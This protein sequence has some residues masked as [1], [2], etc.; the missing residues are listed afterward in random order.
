ADGSDSDVFDDD[1]EVVDLES[2]YTIESTLGKGG[3]GEVLLATDTRLNR[4]V[5]IKRILGSAARSKTA[6]NR[7]L[8]EAQ[9]IAALNHSNIV[10]IYDY[11]RAKDGPFLIMEYVE[12]SSLLDRCRK[13]AIP[14]E[15]SIDLICQL[16]DG[17]GRAHAANIIHRDIKPA[18]VLL[19]TEGVPKLTD[20]GLAKDEA[21]DT[22][23]T[24]QG[25]VL[26]TLDFMPPEQRKDAALTDA[27]SDLWSL[28][29]TLYQMLTG[30]SPRVIDLDEVPSNL[31]KCV[32]KALKTRKDDRYQT[33]LDL[34]QA[35]QE[36]SSNTI[37]ELPPKIELGAGE[38]P[39]CHARNDAGRKFCN[40][41][42]ASLRVGCLE[43]EVE[44][45]AWDKFCPECGCDQNVALNDKIEGFMQQL[46]RAEELLAN[47]AFEESRN[48]VDPVAALADTRFEEVVGRAVK[49]QSTID[50]RR[51]QE[52]QTAENKFNEAK[53]HMAAFDYESAIRIL[54]NVPEPIRRKVDAGEGTLDAFLGGLI[55]DK[56]EFD[57]L[58]K[59]IKTRIKNRELT[60]LHEEVGRAVELRPNHRQLLKL[61]RQLRL[62][63]LKRQIADL[64]R[65][66]KGKKFN[67]TSRETLQLCVLTQEYLTQR[68]GDITIQKLE[69]SSWKR[70]IKIRYRGTN[71]SKVKLDELKYLTDRTAELLGNIG[72]KKIFLNGLVDLSDAAAESLS[73]HSGELHLGG[74]TAVSDAGAE[75][76]SKHKGDLILDGLL[77]LSD[78]AAESLS[79]HKGYLYLDGLTFL[80]DRAAESLSKHKSGFSCDGLANLS[81]SVAES[82]SKYSGDL[83]FDSLKILSD[84]AAEKLSRH[85]GQLLLSGLTSLSDSSAESLSKHEGWI[86][87]DS[88]ISLSDAAAEC[89]SKHRGGLSL[90]GLAGLSDA[91]AESLSNYKDDLYLNHQSNLSDAAA[92]SLANKKG[93]KVNWTECSGLA[94]PADAECTNVQDTSSG[95]TLTKEIAERF[96]ADNK[97]ISIGEFISMHDS[98]AEILIKHEGFLYLNSLADISDAA[99][100]ILSN[101]KGDLWLVGLTSLSD[102]AAESLG[103]F[104]GKH[105]DLDGLESLSD[106]A[107]ESL[108]S[109]EDT[110]LSL[111]GL[112]SISDSAAE[113]LSNIGG[114]LCLDGLKSLS[115]AAA[116]SLC[117]I[118]GWLGLDGLEKF[119]D[120]AKR[121][122][123][124]AGHLKNKK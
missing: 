12:G 72:A 92:G 22:G 117:K 61:E 23:M 6:V 8:T 106:A 69:D 107:A 98:A 34:R 76:L 15:E 102:V 116:E 20:F 39:K 85:K 28:A 17:L 24:M 73:I 52:F 16:C 50:D 79:K 51:K 93:S 13:G 31:R 68:P 49:L 109:L 47:Y 27:R 120:N 111:K 60:D 112:E 14:V 57:S 122:L 105:L 58:I 81:D 83:C 25:A 37:I 21:A 67:S 90:G 59:T 9:S 3:M 78:C 82:F 18:N 35:I 38:C 30:E 110:V 94:N 103:G 43:C 40:S 100:K 75:N 74:L 121:N 1:M 95:N 66:I 53:Q 10:Q 5:A 108:G 36:S 115:D 64:V 2:R 118:E 91:A 71:I 77:E 86:N 56:E 19:T 65:K 41:C 4:K 62:P 124:N 113:S 42:G 32:G 123:V 101:H 29:A 33:A 119:S 11:G 63:K 87:L 70:L 48:I 54:G 7:F 97:S 84:S 89:L 55:D 114:G 45:P 46:A 88:L 99:A 80:S 26:G 44:I 96:L 104:K